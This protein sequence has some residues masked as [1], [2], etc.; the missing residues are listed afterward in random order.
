[1]ED[2]QDK[3]QE[4]SGDAEKSLDKLPDAHFGHQRTLGAHFG[5]FHL[6]VSKPNDAEDELLL[7]PPHV[8]RDFP[9]PENC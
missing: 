5:R 9:P 3:N 4:K 1:M 8:E 2:G 7:L 6:A